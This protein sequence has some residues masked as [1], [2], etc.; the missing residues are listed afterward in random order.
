M[1]AHSGVDDA[2]SAAAGAGSA[3]AEA[4]A[5][6]STPTITFGTMLFYDGEIEIVGTTRVR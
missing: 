6:R 5:V 4:A 3:A 1:A 2:A